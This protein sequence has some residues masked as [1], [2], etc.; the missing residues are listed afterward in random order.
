MRKPRHLFR[1]WP[2]L[3]VLALAVT[4]RG[5]PA[6]DDDPPARQAQSVDISP[7][8]QSQSGLKTQP[9]AAAAVGEEIPAYGRIVDLSPLLDLRAR[10]RAAQSELAVAEAALRLARQNHDR[11]RTLH[12]ESIIPTRELILAE[13]Q[14]AADQARHEAAARHMREV[15]EEAVQSFGGELFH[16]AVE[17]ESKLFQGLLDHTQVLALVT[18]PAGQ[19]LP[20]TARTVNLT[21]GGER[22]KP[23]PARLLAA[24]P[25]TDVSTQ[26]ETWFFAADAQG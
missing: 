13:S 9:L 1:L 8:R 19:S 2:V 4:W 11:L 21:F 20:A 7:K 26:G 3:A 10:Y 22:G 12:S 5:L 25:Q 6:D 15:R 16:Q 17:A 23:R 18:L 24:A 14:L